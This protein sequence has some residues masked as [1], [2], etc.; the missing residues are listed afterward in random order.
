MSY[1]RR[2]VVPPH[3]PVL[4]IGLEGALDA[5]FAAGTAI[6][7]LLAQFDA[8]TFASFD[9]DELIDFRARRPQIRVSDGVRGKLFWPGPRLRVGS[10]AHGVGLSFLV[11]SEPDF[12]WR[13]F[14]KEVTELA[15]ELGTPLVVGFGAV[16]AQTPHTR[17]VLVVSSASDQSLAR[18]IGYRP[19]AWARPARLV[20]VVGSFCV[21]AG[22]PSIGL[23]ALVPHYVATIAF[24]AASL[25]L[26]DAFQSV[27]GLT[28]DTETLRSSA[29]ETKKQVDELI[30]QSQ[31][32]VKML[33]QL[34]K[35]YEDENSVLGGE[36][37]I[38]SGDEIAEELEQYL[39]GE[40][41]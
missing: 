28:I 6:D 7:T 39:R 13:P 37:G 35:Q 36:S 25:A 26:L 12:R 34:E 11:G 4:V 5:G 15:V 9:A 20:D 40:M 1:T 27:T 41:Q 18:K 16:A 32:H 30:A 24:P 14:A 22:I 33:S 2:E 21:E 31:E 3:R 19:G 8:R 38:P 17:P 10:D 29:Q 23:T